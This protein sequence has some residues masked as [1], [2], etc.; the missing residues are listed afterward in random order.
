MNGGAAEGPPTA[1]P[2]LMAYYGD[3]FT[4]TTDSLEALTT[5]GI[6]AAMFLEP[7]AASLLR[8][9]FPHIR[10]FGVAGVGRSLSPA[11]MA[12]EL[13]PTFEALSRSGA[14]VVHYKLCSTFDS[15][16]QLGSIG[17]AIDLALETFGGQRYAPLLVGVPQLRR[18]TVF[19]QHFAAFGADVARLD[20][21]P[22]MSAHPATPMDEA[23]LRLHL[24]K[25]T[26]KRIALFSILD[27]D[28]S[29]ERVARTFDET[30]A[31]DPGIVLFDV[32]DEAR[33]RAAG[34]LLAREAKRG[35]RFVAGSSSVQYALAAHWKES[36]ELGAAASLLR[37]SSPVEQILV[38]SGSCSPVTESQIRHAR[39]RGFTGIRVHPEFFLSDAEGARATILSQAEAVWRAGGSPLVYT[40]LGGEGLN[41]GEL[42]RLMREAGVASPDTGRLIGE[43]LGKVARAFVERCR[44]R[45]M[46]VAGGDTSGY[47]ARALGI[48][49]LECLTPIA[50]GG[51]LCLAHGAEAGVDGLELAL[52]GGQVGQADY[53]ER[54]R[55]GR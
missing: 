11:E 45:R 52:K 55:L 25:Q 20:R 26:D 53:F 32:L 5:A 1:A 30:L 14:P 2:L 50:P 39:S 38:V 9:R 19:G 51:P 34:R 37:P 16:P 7:P 47:V 40:A 27:Q 54:V 6:P 15:S 44:P 17:K 23:D 22:T 10:A 43:Q 41:V 4:G 18:Y 35:V 3:D 48:L 21:H 31:G 12:R 42:K 8:E 46:I 33:L 13:P 29:P 49:G 28:G 36:G 24:A